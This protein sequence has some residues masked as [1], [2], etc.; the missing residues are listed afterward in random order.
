MELF[1]NILLTE[2]FNLSVIFGHF[3]FKP[4]D[5]SIHPIDLNFPSSIHRLNGKETGL[6]VILHSSLLSAFEI[7]LE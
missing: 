7:S 3:D 1:D 5:K 4:I 2:V 6:K